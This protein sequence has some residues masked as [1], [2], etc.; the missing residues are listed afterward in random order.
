MEELKDRILETRDESA[1][2]LETIRKA[3]KQVLLRLRAVEVYVVPS[4]QL[5]ID[6]PSPQP[7]LINYYLFNITNFV[8]VKEKRFFLTFNYLI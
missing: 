2:N 1:S 3:I 5:F 6:S 7:S 4:K 8:K